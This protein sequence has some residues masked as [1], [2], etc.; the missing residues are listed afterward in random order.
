MKHKPLVSICIPTFNRPHY[1]KKALESCFNQTYPHFE[2]I[3]LDASTDN[4]TSIL[5]KKIKYNRIRYYRHKSK[6]RALFHILKFVR[7]EYV[8]IL[9]DDDLLK[10]N[11]L[12]RM[13][14]AFQKNKNVGIVMAPLEIIDE[15]GERI[16]PRFYYFKKM[17]FLYKYLGHDSFVNK[18]QIMKDFLTKKYPCCVPTGIMY[19]KECFN[20]IGGFDLQADFAGDV[21]ICMRIATQFDFY[22][23]NE[24]L[25]SWR[26]NR[27]SHTV[28]LQNK[29]Y[30][31]HA[32]Y[33]LTKKYCS[34]KQVMSMFPKKEVKRIVKDS[35]L[36]ASKRSLL[37]VLIGI[38][39]LDIQI[40]I[41]SLKIILKNDPYITNILKLPF[42]SIK[43]IIDV[44]GS[45]IIFNI[46]TLHTY[47]RKIFEIATE[48]KLR[49]N[50]TLF[51][52]QQADATDKLRESG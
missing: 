34:N 23:I 19:K 12:E 9:L 4:K 40:V 13:V 48:T 42:I 39:T 36:F 46:V 1:L 51:K 15:N 30:N 18:K 45:E 49:Q 14:E 11:C 3:V 37:N 22:Y 10:P 6:E 50:R 31:L 29:G 2:I 7:G 44:I 43:E 32:F 52:I 41:K 35:Y 21:E 24:A 38:K 25:S 33:Y 5:I 16:T 28:N 26:Y 8:K 17:H 47:A 20:A 27:T